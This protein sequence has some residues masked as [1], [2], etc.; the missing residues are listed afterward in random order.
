MHEPPLVLGSCILRIPEAAKI[1]QNAILH[2]HR[3]RYEVLG[4]CV[5]PNH[6]HAIF[7]PL[8]NHTPA[9]ILHSWKSFTAHKINS[10]LYREGTLWERE[11][12]DH[13][14]RSA[15]HVESFVE[16]AENNPV[17]AGFCARAADWPYSSA[18]VEFASALNEPG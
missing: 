12:F 6:V 15:D 9:G 3:K 4:W 13:L 16:Y 2:F 1:V 10:A 17:E 7:S 8:A 5:M 11:S 14:I 18:S